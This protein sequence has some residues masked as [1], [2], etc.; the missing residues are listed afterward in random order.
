MQHPKSVVSQEH[1]D[2][3]DSIEEVVGLLD[4]RIW[5]CGVTENSDLRLVCV[6]ARCS[7]PK[8]T[9]WQTTNKGKKKTFSEGWPKRRREVECGGVM[10]R[11]PVSSRGL[12]DT[13]PDSLFQ[14]G[15]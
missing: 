4:C 3:A 6:V 8:G 5:W 10:W 2:G 13:V 1:I 9:E 14:R 7:R 12:L 15:V 11:W